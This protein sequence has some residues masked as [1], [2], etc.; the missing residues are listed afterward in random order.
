MY[1]NPLVGYAV[2]FV[3]YHE[4]FSTLQLIGYSIIAIAL[5]LFN[6]PNLKRMQTPIGTLKSN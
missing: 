3:V 1:I 6:Y 5:V 4:Q 2:A